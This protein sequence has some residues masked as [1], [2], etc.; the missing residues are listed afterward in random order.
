MP[1][2]PVMPV[3]HVP[4]RHGPTHGPE[5][6]SLVA[7]EL[8]HVD[9]TLRGRPAADTGRAAQA[10]ER[11]ARAIEA[12][13][14]AGTVPAPVVLPEHRP[15]TPSPPAPSAPAVLGGT[16]DI[17]TSSGVSG[18]HDLPRPLDPH[19]PFDPVPPDDHALASATV[20]HAAEAPLPPEPATATVPA[21]EVDRIYRTVRERLHHDL[22]LDRERTGGL[23]EPAWR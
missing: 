21:E 5:V 7:H 14:R 2:T 1:G 16:A 15:S 6:Q 22:V 17:A 18:P 23:V 3:V 12:A 9:A 8:V 11:R 19:R 20:H 10:E 13:V 4:D